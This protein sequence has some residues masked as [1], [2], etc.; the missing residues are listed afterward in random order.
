[1]INS[2]NKIYTGLAAIIIGC[3]FVVGCENE[4]KTVQDLGKRTL[5]VEEGKNIESY[6]S[7]GGKMKAK[8][9][10]PIMLRYML[11][12]PKVEFTKS[13]HVDFFDDTLA[14]ESQLKCKY[15]RYLENDNKVYLKD[16]VIVFNRTGDTLWTEELIWDQTKAEFFTNKFVKVKKG[17]NSTYILGYNGLRSDQSLNNIT[18]FSI[19]EGSYIHIP[20]STY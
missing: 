1:M 18:F 2:S 10:A 14:I 7:Q 17:F 19:R 15:G 8:L 12:T 4:I 11:D 5:G 9:T 20:D 3:F 13:M 6:M 16:S